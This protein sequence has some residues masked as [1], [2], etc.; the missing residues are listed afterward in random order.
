[1]ASVLPIPTILQVA[2]I[3]QYLSANDISQGKKLKSGFLAPPLAIQIFLAKTVVRWIYNLN[4]SDPTLTQTSNY[5]FQLLGG[6]AAQAQA[7]INNVAGGVATITN[8]ANVSINVGQNATFSVTVTSPS[9]YVVQWYR[10]GI[11]IPGATGLSYTLSNAQLADSSSTFYAVAINSAGPIS[12]N[13]ATLTVTAV[14]TGYLYY[15]SSNPGPTLLLSSDPFSYQINYTITHNQPISVPLTV[16]AASNQFLVIKVPS[17][18]SSKS[19]WFNTTLNQGVIPPPAD[20]VFATPVTFGGWTY[21]YTKQLISLDS[22]QP[23]ILS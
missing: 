4:T 3:A 21:Y 1:M 20:F 18:E 19:A 17:T 11:I 6:Y 23:L 8:P 10:N 14:I 15:S 9:P 7:I 12:S 13:V 2:D 5:L 16:P 22:T